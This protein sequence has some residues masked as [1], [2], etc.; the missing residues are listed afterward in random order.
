[1]TSA[2]SWAGFLAAILAGALL[3]F[4]GSDGVSLAFGV[5]VFALCVITAFVIQWVAFVPA[6][7]LRTERFFDL[8]GSATFIGTACVALILSSELSNRSIVIGTLVAIWALR[9]GTF[10]TLRVRREGGDRRFNTIKNSFA[11]FLMTWTLQAV[12]VTVTFG[13]GLAAMVSDE[14]GSIDG[15][16]IAGTVIWIVGFSIEVSADN[17][18]RRFRQSPT[19]ASRFIESGLWRWSR[20]PNYFGE[21]LLWSGIAICAFPALQ[22]WQ[23]VTLISPVFVWLLLTKISGIRMLEASAQKRWGDDPEY[24]RYV[25]NTPML[26]PKPPR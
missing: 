13:P 19:N 25:S 21:I 20:H 26:I 8:V 15:F 10:L 16:L 12:W 6:W 14:P 7:F 2:N 18:K 3:A 4:F 9:L 23:Y 17:Q 11:T 24:I 1:M 5:P 22:G